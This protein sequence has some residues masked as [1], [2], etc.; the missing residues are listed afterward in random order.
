MVRIR[1]TD[2]QL[3]GLCPCFF[4]SALLEYPAVHSRSPLEPMPASATDTIL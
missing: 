4:T 3:S 1:R 2:T